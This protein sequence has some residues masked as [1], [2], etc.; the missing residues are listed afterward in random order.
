[1]FFYTG[2][3]AMS[4]TDQG[5]PEDERTGTKAKANCKR[6]TSHYQ[7]DRSGLVPGMQT[8]YHGLYSRTAQAPGLSHPQLMQLSPKI[9]SPRQKPQSRPQIRY[10]QNQEIQAGQIPIERNNIKTAHKPYIYVHSKEKSIPKKVPIRPS[11]YQG[12]PLPQK[13]QKIE[14]TQVSH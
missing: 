8:G 13:N 14:I 11:A 4:G 5:K 2:K 1:M 7:G 6:C 9:I 3:A 10:A 12:I